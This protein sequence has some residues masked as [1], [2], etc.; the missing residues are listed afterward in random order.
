MLRFGASFLLNPNHIAA[1]E[2][3]RG[4]P[5]M[6]AEIHARTAGGRAFKRCFQSETSAEEAFAHYTRMLASQHT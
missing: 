6:P 2:L 5:G 3:R 1:L 4:K